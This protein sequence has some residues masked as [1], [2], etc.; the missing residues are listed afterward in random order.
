MIPIG[1][2]YIRTTRSFA[3]SPVALASELDKRGLAFT[4]TTSQQLK[5]AWNLINWHVGF[6]ELERLE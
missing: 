3:S 1:N 2:Q 5:T 6:K 4:F